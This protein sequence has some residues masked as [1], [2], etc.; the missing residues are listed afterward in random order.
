MIDAHL[1]SQPAECALLLVDQQA[2]LAFGVGSTDRQIL[3][4]N[5]VTLAGTATALELPIIVSTSVAKFYSAP[6]MPAI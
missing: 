4:N 6:L 3:L 5:T 2:G 1:R